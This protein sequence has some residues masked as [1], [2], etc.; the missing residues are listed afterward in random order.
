MVETR[1][2]VGII[3]C[4]GEEI[5]EG[6]ISRNAV[7]RVLESLR[8]GRTVTLCLPL[9]LAGGEEERAFARNH[10]VVAV[11][12]CDKHCA[13][14]GTEMHSG[15]VSAS[16]TVTDILGGKAGG[17]SRSARRLSDADAEAVW[18]VADRVASAVDALLEGCPD[19]PDAIPAGAVEGCACSRPLPAQSITVGN[20]AVPLDGLALI[21]DQLAEEGVAPDERSAGRILEKV[22][23]YHEVPADEDSLYRS[24]LLLVYCEYR[25]NE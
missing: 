20:K 24:A 23:I 10:P 4:S 8:P 18:V 25:R 6:T 17:C 5:P 21:F 22:K 14:R 1:R 12:G 15:P 19:A 13:K 2:K 16:L 7:R 9:F 3:S 11:D